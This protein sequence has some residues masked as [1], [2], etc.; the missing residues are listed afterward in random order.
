MTVLALSLFILLSLEGA[1]ILFRF[2]E[3]PALIGEIR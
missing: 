2:H 3:A 1:C